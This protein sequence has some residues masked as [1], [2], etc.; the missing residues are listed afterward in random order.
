[1]VLAFD[2]SRVEAFDVEGEADYEV[3]CS[4][5]EELLKKNPPVDAPYPP[6]LGPGGSRLVACGGNHAVVLPT[7]E[8]Y[9]MPR[10]SPPPLITIAYLVGRH[11]LRGWGRIPYLPRHEFPGAGRLTGEEFRIVEPEADYLRLVGRGGDEYIAW[12][13][14][15]GTLDTGEWV[16]VGDVGLYLAKREEDKVVVKRPYRGSVFDV[17]GPPYMPYYPVVPV[18]WVRERLERVREVARRL[19][20]DGGP[21]IYEPPVDPQILLKWPLRNVQWEFR[22]RGWPV[23]KIFPPMGVERV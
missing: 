22:V 14:V 7:L 19:L 12:D 8:L 16:L 2:E 23:R 1:M 18:K 3:E 13:F 17:R 9:E 10:I 20:W 5:V 11:G 21:Y 6:L 15:L 4:G